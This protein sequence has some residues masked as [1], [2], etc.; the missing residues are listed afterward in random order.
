MQTILTVDR[1]QLLIKAQLL[2]YTHNL[3]MH[4]QVFMKFVY[5][6]LCRHLT[7]T[8]AYV[9]YACFNTHTQ[10]KHYVFFTFLKKY[11]TLHSSNRSND[12]TP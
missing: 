10:P 2:L 3:Y 9:P 6:Y 8:T 1:V 5:M 4:L 12:L 7:H 11:R